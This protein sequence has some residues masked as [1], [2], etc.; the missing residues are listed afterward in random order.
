VAALYGLFNGIFLA[1]AA[2]LWRLA[3][4]DSPLVTA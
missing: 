4:A 3:R 1:R 2:R